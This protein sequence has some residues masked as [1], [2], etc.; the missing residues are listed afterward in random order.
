MENLYL[1]FW[2]LAQADIGRSIS[3]EH[4]AIGASRQEHLA[5]G[6][7]RQKSISHKPPN[8]GKL[9]VGLLC[10]VDVPEVVVEGHGYLL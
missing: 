5:K 8:R 7:S 1:H 9:I 6:A 10:F 4:L 3:P 2:K